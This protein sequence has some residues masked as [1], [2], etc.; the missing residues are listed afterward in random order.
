MYLLT[1]KLFDIV[2]L[3]IYFSFYLLCGTIKLP[4]FCLS[5]KRLIILRNMMQ[6]AKETTALIV[7]YTSGNFE[8]NKQKRTVEQLKYK[9]L[10]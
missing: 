3:F 4:D 8:K 2:C 7:W 10:H 1:K 6:C 5:K 9:L